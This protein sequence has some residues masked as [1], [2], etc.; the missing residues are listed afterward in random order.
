M[1]RSINEI[2]QTVLN[3]QASVQELSALEV[4]TEQEQA[5]TDIT[6]VSKLSIW[7]NAVYS[8]AVAVWHLERLWDIFKQETET[9]I[10]ETRPHTMDWYRQMGL[11]YL[12]GVPLVP[13]TDYYDTSGLTAEQIAQAKII[14]NA[15]C[16]K[17]ILYGAG[18]L[19][20]KVVKLVN[21]EYVPLNNDELTGFTTYMNEVSDAGTL[22]VCTTGPADMLRIEL[23]VYYNPTVLNSYGQ[24]LDGTD[25]TPVQSAIKNY[26]KSLRFNGSFI[27]TKLVN[28]LEAVEGVFY[29]EIKNA[30][31]KYGAYGYD[32]TGVANVG[33]IDVIRIADAGHMMLDE[34]LLNINWIPYS[35]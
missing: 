31:S 14:A 30:W 23:D 22:V 25:A 11:N 16:I 19:R 35:E 7:R 18:R 17:E 4:L 12:H 26:L 34:D 9:R 13:G 32:T 21:G 1:A 29:P 24:R 2:Q 33:L 5:I 6:S 8:F 10:A 28:E 3:A 15:A 27:K 20:F